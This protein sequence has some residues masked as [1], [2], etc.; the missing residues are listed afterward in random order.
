MDAE[1]QSTLLFI[2]KEHITTLAAKIC[3]GT[4]KAC[5]CQVTKNRGIT[6][7]LTPSFSKKLRLNHLVNIGATQKRHKPR[8][9]WVNVN[10]LQSSI[11]TYAKIKNNI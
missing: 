11:L 8:V 5:E 3:Y 4:N 2:W 10:T 6:N 7:V 1:V 9:K